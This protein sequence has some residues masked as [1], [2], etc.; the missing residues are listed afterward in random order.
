MESLAMPIHQIAE[1]RHQNATMMDLL[2]GLRSTSSCTSESSGPEL[3]QVETLEDF[4][5][6]VS[7]LGDNSHRQQ[8]VAYLS[9]LGG[10]KV[11]SF[12]DSL[13]SAVLGKNHLL[14]HLLRSTTGK[15]A[16]LWNASV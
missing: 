4:D 1:L 9:T 15:E 2:R 7:A 3:R 6:L 16:V 14:C 12:V 10:D 5:S 13:R 11:V 8:L